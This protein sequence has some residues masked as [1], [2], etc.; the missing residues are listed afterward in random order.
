LTRVGE[1]R[2]KQEVIRCLK[3]YIVRA[4]HRTLRADLSDLALRE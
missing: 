2:T 1:G 3:R 4:V